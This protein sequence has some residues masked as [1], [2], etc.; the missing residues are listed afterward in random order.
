MK[1]ALPGLGHTGGEALLV[2]TKIY[3]RAVAALRTA[4]GDDLHA[5]SHITGG[6]LPGNV[7]RVL[8]DGLGV[9]I[10]PST[11]AL[12]PIFALVAQHGDVSLSE[13]RLAFNMGLGLVAVAAPS[14]ARA[15]V[16]ALGAAGETA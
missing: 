1:E 2:P 5:L 15:A 14:D 7:P 10:D 4:C 11:W 3:A 9:A 8:P 6:G 16:D 12:P 13:M